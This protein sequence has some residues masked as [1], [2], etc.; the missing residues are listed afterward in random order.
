MSDIAATGGAYF[1]GGL[2]PTRSLDMG[3]NSG[4][5]FTGVSTHYRDAD[6]DGYGNPN[7]TSEQCAPSPGYVTNNTDCNDNNAA[8]HPGAIEICGNG[9]DDNCDG[10][11]DAGCCTGTASAGADQTICGASS[12]TLSANAT[13]GGN[14]TGGAGSFAPNRNAASA[15][16]T[17]AAGEIGTTI[18]LTWNV[19]DPDGTGPCTATTD[20]MNIVIN[21]QIT[22]TFTQLGP[23]C[24]N[25]TAPALPGI[26]NNGI[27]GTW[28]PATINTS[29]AGTTT[30]T[31]TP[32]AV[33]VLHLLQ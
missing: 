3:G 16:Y 24:Q 2:S 10:M 14:W 25:S 5:V 21:T 9:I 28:S 8:I 6:G 31:F 29:T 13:P 22:P 11:I 20:S 30:Y 18:T 15:T 27:N 7:V 19:P 12:I 23:L 17:P 1:N 26:S 32:A 4:W 33:S